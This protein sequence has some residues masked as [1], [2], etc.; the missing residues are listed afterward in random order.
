M[1]IYELYLIFQ[2]KKIIS[3][4]LMDCKVIIFIDFNEYEIVNSNVKKFHILELIKV[5]IK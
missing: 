5:F 2:K 3:K 4:E 1:Q